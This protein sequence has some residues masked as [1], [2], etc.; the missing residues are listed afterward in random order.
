MTLTKLSWGGVGASGG[1]GQKQEKPNAQPLLK[2]RCIWIQYLQRIF[3]CFDRNV[4]NWRLQGAVV[5]YILLQPVLQEKEQKV[6]SKMYTEITTR[7]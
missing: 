1:T 4:P 7:K 2:A 3:D 5:F 6:D